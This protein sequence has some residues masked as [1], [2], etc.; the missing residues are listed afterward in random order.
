MIPGVAILELDCSGLIAQTRW[1]LPHQAGYF[2]TGLDETKNIVDQQQHVAMLVVPEIFSHCQRC[3]AHAEAAAR[4]LVHLAEHHH[5]V[6]QYTSFLHLTVK[7]LAF[8]TA[9][10]DTAKQTDPF[11]VPD[12]VVDHFSE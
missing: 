8:A 11:V 3:V 7:L 1:H 10:T 4:R 6:R 12:H 2:H 5:H 9:F